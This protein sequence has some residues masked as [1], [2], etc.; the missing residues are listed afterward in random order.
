MAYVFMILFLAASGG[1]ALP[2][3]RNWK[4]KHFALAA[5]AAFIG[6]TLTVPKPTSEELAADHTAAVAKARSVLNPPSNYTR[7]EYGSTF[8]RVGAA[9]FAKLNELEP[10]AVYAAAEST[11][12][13]K[14]NYAGVSEKSKPGDAVWFV[15]CA[16][17]NR[18][19][20]HQKDAAEA[21]ARFNQ[22]KLAF[23]KLAASCTLST[24]AMCKA[25]SAQRAALANELELA[26]ACDL[27]LDKAL[28]SP[29]SVNMVGRWSVGFGE[30]DTVTISR[31]FDSQNSFGA[32]IRSRYRC[33]VNAAT[34]NVTG[35]VVEDP[36]GA[37]RVI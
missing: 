27:I 15:D 36:M 10:G 25:S 35:F 37:K 9:T 3:I 23:H 13:N 7:A 5:F 2:Y 11:S 21:L 14:V 29:S 22:G 31:D 4:R 32:M 18:F 6:M 34:D 26:S 16:N 1:I 33:T 12:C 19:V 24:T 20:I 8:K 28:V 17:Q 30:N